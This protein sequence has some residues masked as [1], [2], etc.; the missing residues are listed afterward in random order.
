MPL[1]VPARLNLFLR[2]RTPAAL[3]NLVTSPRSQA[4]AWNGERNRPSVPGC[5]VPP[6]WNGIL[7]GRGA[8]PTGELRYESVKHGWRAILGLA[9]RRES[10]A[11][12]GLAHECVGPVF[13][14]RVGRS[15]MSPEGAARSN[16][17]RRRGIV[18]HRQIARKTPPR[19][20]GPHRAPGERRM[21]GYTPYHRERSTGRSDSAANSTPDRSTPGKSRDSAS[22]PPSR[23]RCEVRAV[24][25]APIQAVR[26]HPARRNPS[27]M[28]GGRERFDTIN[29]VGARG[30]HVGSLTIEISERGA[31][32]RRGT[33]ESRKCDFAERTQFGPPA[34]G[35][36]SRGS[37]CWEETWVLRKGKC[38]TGKVV[39]KWE[40]E[41]KTNPKRSQFRALRR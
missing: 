11:T 4:G 1:G 32:R 20:N 22:A 6:A 41:A 39:W 24:R 18:L 23:T 2:A 16:E 26:P 33:G 38:R 19:R 27:P 8:R 7:A 13:W 14:A 10:G 15:T 31:D 9:R 36:S 40:N 3:G 17:D 30:P 37:R 34:G 21:R 35:V 5:G 28:I 25:P 12:G 29:G